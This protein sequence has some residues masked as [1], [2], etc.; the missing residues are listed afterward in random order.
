MAPPV[1]RH[2]SVRIV[3]E[4]MRKKKKELMRSNS[5][6]TVIEEEEGPLSDTLDTEDEEEKYLIGSLLISRFEKEVSDS[7]SIYQPNDRTSL[8]AAAAADIESRH[9]LTQSLLSNVSGNQ[10]A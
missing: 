6:M 2:D 5:Q 4:S 10:P 8:A 3:T 1:E 9:E 7:Q